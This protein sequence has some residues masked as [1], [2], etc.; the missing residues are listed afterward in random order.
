[1]T[2]P[3]WTQRIEQVRRLSGGLQLELRQLFPPE[4]LAWDGAWEYTAFAMRRLDKVCQLYEREEATRQEVAE[5]GE[6]WRA[7]WREAAELF[8]TQ[9]IL[10]ESAT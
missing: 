3:D 9:P 2:Q 5:A 10:A 8:V 6:A 7:A 4:L 1:M